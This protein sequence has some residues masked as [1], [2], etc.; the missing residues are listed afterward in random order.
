M[1]FDL[2]VRSSAPETNR[3]NP[4]LD[5]MIAE[6][7]EK[8]EIARSEGVFR[9]GDKVM[10]IRNNYD[11]MWKKCDGSAVGT[12]MFNGDIERAYLAGLMHDYARELTE[13]ELNVELEKGYADMKAGRTK[14]AKAVF[15]EIRKDYAL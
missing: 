3:E 11:I 12:G 2:A 9:L 15:E 7:K 14:S 13:E 10:Q 5:P 6:A 1:I 4:F 8:G